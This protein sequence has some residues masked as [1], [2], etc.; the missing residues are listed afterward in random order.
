MH[1]ILLALGLVISLAGIVLI[2]FGVRRDGLGAGDTLLMVGTIA[3]VG[4]LGLI[5]LASAIRQLRRIAQLLEPRPVPRALGPEPVVGAAASAAPAVAVPAPVLPPEPRF[6]TG[7]RPAAAAPEVPS[8]RPEDRQPAAVAVPVAA[9]VVE[10]PPAQPSPPTAPLPRRAFEGFWRRAPA[11]DAYSAVATAVI[12]TPRA[13]RDHVEPAAATPQ[14]QIFKS[15]VIDG[16]AYTLYTDGSIEAEVAEGT[17]KFASIDE[18]RAYLA[19]R[20]S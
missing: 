12:E 11:P 19:S 16:M 4:S 15:G 3:L 7:E 1:V 5:G 17:V 8:V 14:A 18:L 10:E 13:D 2:G 6:E 9:A 20:E